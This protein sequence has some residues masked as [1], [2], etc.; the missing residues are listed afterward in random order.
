MPQAHADQQPL[1]HEHDHQRGVEQE[2][3]GSSAPHAS[4]NMASHRIVIDELDRGNVARVRALLP[5]PQLTF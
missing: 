3:E 5:A 1:D 4:P 2:R